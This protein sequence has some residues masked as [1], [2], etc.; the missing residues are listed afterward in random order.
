M[1][2]REVSES[3]RSAKS[4]IVEGS[5]K[6]SDFPGVSVFTLAMR[7]PKET[8]FEEMG[9][10]IPAKIV[11]DGS[12]AL[13]LSPNLNSY[14]KDPVV[15][16][17]NCA[18]IVSEWYQLQATLA[19]PALAGSGKFE[20]NGQT[21]P[22]Q[23]IRGSL[24]GEPPWHESIKRTLCVD[25]DRKLIVWEKSEIKGSSRTYT[26][27]RIERNADLP[28]SVFVFAPP[29]GTVMMQG[30]HLPVL[31]PLGSREIPLD[32][33]V[34]LPKLVS[35]REPQYDE[36]SRRRKIEGH[37][38]LYVIIDQNGSASDLRVFRSLTPGLDA[39]AI[40]SVRQWRFTPAMKNGQPVAIAV[41]I[42]VNFRLL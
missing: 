1:L 19:S 37:V 13:V 9:G 25:V 33:G 10:P 27:S 31:R 35:H 36:D 28:D 32:P 24:Q 2:L 42:D 30:F 41:T 26:Y 17:P 3:A 20:I 11:C 29:P 4:W 23:I 5:I 38:L 14:T 21:S 12:N 18:P 22:C 39:Q 34:L 6:Y 15:D 7:S 40:K 8:R 16:Y